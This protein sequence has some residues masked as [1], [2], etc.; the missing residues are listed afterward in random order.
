MLATVLLCTFSSIVLESFGP[1]SQSR[2]RERCND[3]FNI[4]WPGHGD[5]VVKNLPAKAGNTGSLV[6]EAPTCFEAT[7]PVHRNH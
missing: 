6:W 3:L 2:L 4:I 5:P 7:K 1:L